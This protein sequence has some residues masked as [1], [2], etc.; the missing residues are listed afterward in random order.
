MKVITFF[1]YDSKRYDEIDLGI[2]EIEKI[3]KLNKGF[4]HEENGV[5]TLYRD[6]IKAKQYVGFSAIDD[7]L[8]QVLPKI[9]RENE[10]IHENSMERKASDAIEVFLKM[11]SK[12][13]DIEIKSQD[14]KALA[15]EDIRLKGKLH[16]VLIYLFLK[17]LKDEI[18]K[19]VYHE[20]ITYRGEE[21]FLKG[22]LLLSKQLRKLPYEMNTFAVEYHMFS[23]DNL[24]N[25]VF[26]LAIYLSNQTSKWRRNRE[27]SSYLSMIFDTIFSKSLSLSDMENI[28]FTRL[29]KRFKLCYNMARIILQGLYHLVSKE[30]YGFFIDMNQL[31]EKFICQIIKKELLKYS[32]SCQENLGTIIKRGLSNKEYRARPDYSIKSDNRNLLIVMDAKYK[33]LEE[34][35]DGEKLAGLQMSDI[36]QMYAYSKLLENRSNKKPGVIVLIYPMSKYFNK[37]L[38]SSKTKEIT[39]FDESRIIVTTYN[40]DTLLSDETDKKFINHL[41]EILELIFE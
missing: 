12:A 38:R 17:N 34:E 20:Y 18:E 19:G 1:E 5:F 27:L 6:V 25:Q 24:L 26:K 41:R 4:G 22:K 7:K 33:N 10:D 32:V 14:I 9:Y 16:E 30:I 36:Y 37:Q 39:F 13:Y 31:F 3:K 40:L 2:K 8:I 23:E 11:I 15:R 29:N 28:H 35:S 21:S